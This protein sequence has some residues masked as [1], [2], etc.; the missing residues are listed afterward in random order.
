MN[1]NID[2]I[3]RYTAYG[4]VGASTVRG[5]RTKGVVAAARTAL[6][7]VELSRYGTADH[8]EF[9]FALE[10]D[11][12]S[13][14]DGLPVG[15]RYWGVAR[16]V[17]NIF[18]RGSLYNIYLSNY[19]ELAQAEALFEIPLD[20]LSA[21]AIRELASERSIPRWLGVKYVTPEINERFQRLAIEVATERKTS[22][23]H[24]DALF[25]GSR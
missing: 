4:S 25:W 20:S 9:T 3:R 2:I 5:L 18:L 15:A 1:E 17:L 24:L 21:N 14:C 7:K 23:V 11:T 22:R 12:Q 13:V 8:A 10:R 16:K 6:S 19:F